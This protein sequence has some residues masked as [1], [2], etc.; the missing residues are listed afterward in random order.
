MLQDVACRASGFNPAG[1]MWTPT[2]VWL[3]SSSFNKFV[4]T[5]LFWTRD[6]GVFGQGRDKS[7]RKLPP[8]PAGFQ[9]Q[10]PCICISQSTRSHLPVPHAAFQN[11]SKGRPRGEM[12]LLALPSM[13]LL[14][15]FMLS[16]VPSAALHAEDELIITPLDT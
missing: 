9:A 8:V 14:Q 1:R 13:C 6:G 16:Y 12:L 15:D 10:S 5:W 2:E 11:M 4:R 3:A 7:N